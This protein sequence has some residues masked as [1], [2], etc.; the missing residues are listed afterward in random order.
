MKM[1]IASNTWAS[2]VTALSARRDVESA[3]LLFVETVHA[4]H[5][6]ALVVRE[7]SAV[8]EPAYAIRRRDQLRLEPIALN[9]L[10]RPARDRGLGVFTI[11]TH[12]GARTAEFSAA[13]DR[14]DA[15][16]LP[17]FAVQMPDAVHGS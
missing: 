16:L 3:G 14:G 13:D 2:L 1:R 4:A 10:I 11:H 17:S 15:R 6:D 12:P 8:P 5:G 7:A 9:R